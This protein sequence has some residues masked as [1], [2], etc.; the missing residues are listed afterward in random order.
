MEQKFLNLL[1]DQVH[2][3]RK[4]EGGFKKEA[5]TTIERKFNVEM[6]LNLSKENLKN[7][8]KGWKQG[9]RV[10]RELKNMSGFAWNEATQCVDVD[11][12]V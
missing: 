3:G 1:L 2:L 12:M 5:W 8:L 7:K 11:Y 6:N 9:F 10:M 4:G